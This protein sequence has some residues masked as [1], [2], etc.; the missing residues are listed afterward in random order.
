MMALA[1]VARAQT[2]PREAFRATFFSGDAVDTFAADDLARYLN[3][4]DA[5]GK[6]HRF[7]AGIDFEYRLKGKADDTGPQV[8]IYG[9][10]VHGTRS[11]DVDCK[12]DSSLSVCASIFDPTKA[13]A[14]TLF[15][16]RNASTLEAFAGARVELIDLNSGSSSPAKVYV[17]GQM[18]FLA[19][20]RSG[21]DVVDAHHLGVGAIATTGHFQGSHLEVGVGKTDLYR[22]TTGPRLK[23]DGMLVINPTRRGRS[24]WFQP[25]IQMTV[26]ADGDD[27]P[28]SVQSFVGISV[29]IDQLFK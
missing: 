11:A 27:G 29:D 8:W 2:E 16:L 23:I 12:A 13:G 20:E 28:D 14:R 1:S 5:G 21:K 9:E 3:P 18:G 25:F 24:I 15:I 10:T 4:D 7:V 17:R 22:D 19:V 26:D 6:R